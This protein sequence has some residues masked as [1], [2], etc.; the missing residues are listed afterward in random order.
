MRRREVEILEDDLDEYPLLARWDLE[1]PVD[2]AAEDLDDDE[3]DD[4]GFRTLYENP[5]VMLRPSRSLHA[6]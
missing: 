5:E 6:I 3:S 2:L 4:L 1:V